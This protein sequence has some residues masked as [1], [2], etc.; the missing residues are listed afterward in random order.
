M[1]GIVIL[2]GLLCC[3]ITLEALAD[4]QRNVELLASS[5]A[6]CHGT[7][8]HSVG[9]I[10]VLAGLHKLHFIEQMRQLSSGDRPSTVMLHHASGYTKD[11]IE[12]M[13]EF[14]QTE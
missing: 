13:A 7:Q 14:F 5:C 1:R 4:E 10:P 12:L 2:A 9:G 6:A 3:F 8:G 11:E